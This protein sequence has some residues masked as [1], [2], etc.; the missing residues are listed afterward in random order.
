MILAITTQYSGITTL[1]H[2]STVATDKL[3]E[4]VIELYVRNLALG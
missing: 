1:P 4:Y 2:P 3:V